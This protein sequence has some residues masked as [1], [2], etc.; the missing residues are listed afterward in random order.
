[1]TKKDT[2]N[3]LTILAILG[4]KTA[5]SMIQSLLPSLFWDVKIKIIESLMWLSVN[6][7]PTAMSDI[8]YQIEF[9]LIVDQQPCRT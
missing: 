5:R 3:A 4:D 7:D 2:I 6:N 8:S 9:Y 1:M